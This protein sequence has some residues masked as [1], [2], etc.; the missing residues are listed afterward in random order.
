MNSSRQI[1]LEKEYILLSQVG[2]GACCHVYKAIHIPTKSI[3]AI[4]NYYKYSSQRNNTEECQREID[5][6]NSINSDYVAHLNDVFYTKLGKK[7]YFVY[8]YLEFDLQ[9][10]IRS[11]AP[12]FLS[13]AHIS[14]LFS[15]ILM[16]L[17]DIH[18]SHVIHLDIKPGNI[19]VTPQN[20]VKIIDF[21]ISQREDEPNQP[22]KGGT[23]IYMPPEALLNC[24]PMS[25]ANDLWSAGVTLYEMI[26]HKPL[27][28]SSDISSAL[29]C[30]RQ[31][32]GFPTAEDL[33]LPHS[34]ILQISKY[35]APNTMHPFL[36]STINPGTIPGSTQA[37]CDAAI[38]LIM[39]LI[40]F[41]PS[42]RIK[43]KRALGHPFIEMFANEAQL[44]ELSLHESHQERASGTIRSSISENDISM[45][46]PA[47]IVPKTIF[48]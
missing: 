41:N 1:N 10:I 46:R 24:L 8:P 43:A 3:V 16:G 5:I 4:K 6:A 39:K 23:V 37:E 31:R 28:S 29:L 44:P 12:G 30:I 40:S 33:K 48:A 9:G 27:V 22:N 20:Q 2:V 21:G 47:K 35:S 13:M 45:L 25:Q 32:I 36:T 15:Q 18:E 7:L 17:R 38:D 34:K 11:T 26:T 19:L 14:Y 42:K